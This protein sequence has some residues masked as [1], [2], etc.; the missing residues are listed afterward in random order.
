MKDF[1]TI[2]HEL[3]DLLKPGGG[4]K[5]QQECLAEAESV[6]ALSTQDREIYPVLDHVR[7]D[8]VWLYDTDGKKYL[9]LT[10]GVAVRAFGAFNPEVR[11]FQDALNQVILHVASTDFDTIPQIELAKALIARTPAATPRQVYFTTSGARAVETAVKSVM[12]TTHKMTFVAFNPAFHGRTGFSLPLTSSKAVQREF[13]PMAFPVIRGTYPYVYRSLF[14]DNPDIVSTACLQQ[15][16]ELVDNAG[17][18]VGAIF[19]EPVAGEG[20]IIPAP[21]KFVKGLAEYAKEIG[22]LLVSDEVQAG[23]GR[24][25]TFWAI[26]N[27]GVDADYITAGKALGGGLPLAA[28]IGPKP[29]F[30]ERGRHSETFGAEPYVSLLGLFTVRMIARYLDNARLMGDKLMDALKPLQNTYEVIGDVRGLGLLVGVEFVKDR[31]SKRR[32]PD[33]AHAVLKAAV[34]EGLLLLPAGQNT[35]RFLPPL[36]VTEEIIHEGVARFERAIQSTLLDYRA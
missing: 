4:G 22:A 17:K 16:R 18:Q 29:M 12:D 14:G 6:L 2:T 7:G 28:C 21:A 27:F 3:L 5:S 24:T 26:E 36:D 31:A 25:G 11:Q 9:D 10:C 34:D 23:L 13:Y 1:E 30:T 15:L 20:G 32:A 8:W 35:I 33:L 19:I